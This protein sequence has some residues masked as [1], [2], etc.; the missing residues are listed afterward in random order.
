[1]RA[2]LRCLTLV[3]TD[4]LLYVPAAVCV[5]MVCC[6]AGGCGVAILLL[7]L[8]TE[9]L[10]KRKISKYVRRD[11]ENTNVQKKCRK[12]RKAGKVQQV[13]DGGGVQLGT[14]E[15]PGRCQPSPLRK[16]I[17]V[18]LCGLQSLDSFCTY[19]NTLIV[20]VITHYTVLYT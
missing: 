12:Q 18:C 4:V 7:P 11:N 14:S 20:F 8:C 6:I 3:D 9:K 5:I 2:C 1:M 17:E 16:K 15:R 13:I 19:V 10:K